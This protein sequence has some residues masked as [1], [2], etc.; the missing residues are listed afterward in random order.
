V[1]VKLVLPLAALLL[2]AGEAVMI[3]PLAGL[4]EFTVSV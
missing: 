2:S 3:T 4:A 1:S